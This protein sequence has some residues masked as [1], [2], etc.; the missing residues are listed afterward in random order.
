MEVASPKRSSFR[1]D[2]T[3]SS[4]VDNLPLGCTISSDGIVFRLFSPLADQ[5]FLVVFDSYEHT[6]G[7]YYV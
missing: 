5:V 6:L 4:I 1:K 3:K 7:T 2:T